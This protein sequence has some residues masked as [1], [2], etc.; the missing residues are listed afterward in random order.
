M[1]NLL[2]HILKTKK[3][4]MDK[5]GEQLNKSAAVPIIGVSRHRIGTDGDGVTTLVAF[6]G[7]NLRC[8]YC[9]NPE[10]LGSDVGVKRYTPESLYEKVKIDDLYFRSTGGGITFGGGEP[11]LQADFITSFRELCGNDWKIRLETSLNAPFHNIE[12]LVPIVDEWIIDIKTDNGEI[13]E[14]YTGQKY[15]IAFRHLRWLMMELGSNFDRLTLRVPEIPG[16]VDKE[17]ATATKERFERAGISRI[18]QFTYRIENPKYEV[19]GKIGKRKCE[20]MKSIRKDLSGQFGIQMQERKCDY[21]GDCPGTCP[22][23]DYEL[24]SLTRQIRVIAPE[25]LKV[26]DVIA[27]KCKLTTDC[28]SVAS[29]NM[30]MI[31]EDNITVEEQGQLMS[32]EPWSDKNEEFGRFTGNILCTP[33]PHFTYKKN[34][35]KECGVVG[36]S[37]H[38]KRWNH[39]IKL[40]QLRKGTK[41]ALIRDYNNT[42]DKNAV[43]VVL[44][45][46]YDYELSV[47]YDIEDFDFIIGYIPRTD[48]AEIAAMMDAGY[49]D[50]FEA[51]I[52]TYKRYGNYD[53]RIRITIWLL[54][55]EPE[56]E[57][58]FY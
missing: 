49:S 50:K 24:E 33:R 53:D 38:R 2:N 22:L 23:C 18:E 28:I 25:R 47:F 21:D 32:D 41:L 6:H 36:L 8:K 26:S 20:L 52:T 29:D 43:A 57:K 37:L 5:K 19:K 9:L 40:Y 27:E 3:C 58:I 45:D 48:N 51:E 10:S 11:C 12:K 4:E 34:F 7:C 56:E 46:D 17:M 42:Y 35:F 39:L 14:R 55:N 1:K 44:A 54:S 16:F 15:E 31:P 30:T 13:Y